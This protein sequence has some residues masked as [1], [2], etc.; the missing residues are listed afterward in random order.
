MKRGFYIISL[1]IVVAVL[2]AGFY[3]AL[4]RGKTGNTAPNQVG[5]SGEATGPVARVKTAPIR[6]GTIDETIHV[7]GSVIPAP[8]AVRTI[9]VAYES[10]IDSV[11]VNEGQEVSSGNILLHV[12]PSPETRLKFS[13]AGETY[14]VAKQAL[15]NMERKF[16]L[17]L[18]TNDQLL[19]AQ[20][21]S[22]QA[23]LALS[24][25]KN[26]GADGP[27]ELKA[28]TRGLVSKVAVDQGSIVAAGAPLLQIVPQRQLEMRLGV[29]PEDIGKIR[30]DME[31]S[32]SQPLVRASTVISGKVRKIS[33]S[34]NAQT[35]LVDVFVAVASPERFLLGQWVSGRIVV[36]AVSGLIVPRSAVLP[37]G[38][39]FTLFVVKDGRA[40]KKSVRVLAESQTE[41]AVA[42]AEISTGDQVVVVGNYELTNKMAV[43]V[44][45]PR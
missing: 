45:S 12:S 13:Q 15:T 10:R 28:D 22:E 21:S 31:V 14:R 11:M 26:Q 19:Q 43:T 5:A 4:G 36:S 27:R 29:E 16:Q 30:Q 38:K 40:L 3:L 1:F 8:G 2:A 32:L 41:T 6:Q 25:M 7:Y 20:Q 23:D 24:S 17:K 37:E 44:E 18:A 33:R 9:S 39:S 42:G 35:R 34:I